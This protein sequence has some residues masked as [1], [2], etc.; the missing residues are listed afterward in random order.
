MT[1]NKTDVVEMTFGFEHHLGNT[2][3]LPLVDIKPTGRML[4]PSTLAR[5]CGMHG[6]KKHKASRP[7]VS[8]AAFLMRY[9]GLNVLYQFHHF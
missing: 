2:L 1:W 5:W 9:C 6:I 7:S 3:P 8:H 4:R